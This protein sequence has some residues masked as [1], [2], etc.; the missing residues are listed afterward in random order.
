LFVCLFW[1]LFFRDRVSLCSPGCPGTH[2]VDQAG[3]ELRNPPAS[4]SGVLGLKACATMP[5]NALL[6]HLLLCSHPTFC[7]SWCQINREDCPK[8]SEQ[9]VNVSPVKICCVKN[10][11][12]SGSVCFLLI[13]LKQPLEELHHFLLLLLKERKAELGPFSLRTCIQHCG[14]GTMLSVRLVSTCISGRPGLEARGC[15]RWM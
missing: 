3:L 15:W 8:I 6:L 12:Q 1:F 7:K 14:D 11:I 4:A 2:F 5:G 10:K 9:H 13:F